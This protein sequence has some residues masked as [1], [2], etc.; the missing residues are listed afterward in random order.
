MDGYNV[1]RVVTRWDEHTIVRNLSNHFAKEAKAGLL[2]KLGPS[3]VEVMITTKYGGLS[4]KGKDRLIVI[5][6]KDNSK[7]VI[8]AIEL[9]LSVAR[10]H[11]L[12]KELKIK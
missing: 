6:M 12:S 7:Q 8:D 4:V 9:E 10:M 1:A 3:V 11:E 5:K 2:K